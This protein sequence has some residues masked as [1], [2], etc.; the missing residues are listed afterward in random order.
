MPT[1]NIPDKI[2]TH[3]GGTK[4]YIE[5]KRWKR[6]SGEIMTKPNY[7]CSLKRREWDRIYTE[8][9]KEVKKLNNKK[10]NLKRMSK[11]EGKN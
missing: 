3:C 7:K 4:W 5:T 2:C 1:I 8:R 11:T 10:T 6:T 9:N